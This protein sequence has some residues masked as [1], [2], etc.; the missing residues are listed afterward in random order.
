M[1]VRL[2]LIFGRFFLDFGDLF[3]PGGTPG[4]PEDPQGV[5][6]RFLMDFGWISGVPGEALGHPGAHFSALGRSRGALEG[7]KVVKK[8]GPRSSSVPGTILGAQPDAPGP[9]KCG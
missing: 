5:Q 4:H 6:R 3:G 1:R 7:K 8:G 2:R 9:P